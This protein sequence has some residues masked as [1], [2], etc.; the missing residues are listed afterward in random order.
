MSDIVA[1]RAGLP[2][3]IIRFALGQG[4]A[5]A[6]LGVLAAGLL[7]FALL[8]DLLED[9]SHGFDQAILLALRQPGAPDQPIGPAW[10]TLSIREV[11]ALGSIPVLFLL[12]LLALGYL[13]LDRRWRAAALLLVSLP[14]GLLVNTLLKDAFGRPRPDLVARLAEVQTASFPSGH[15]MLSAIGFLTLGALLAAGARRRRHRAY[16]L[17]MAALLTLL[18]GAS[19]VW[20][21]VH[22]PTDVLAGWCLGAAWAMACWLALRK[23]RGAA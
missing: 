3:R 17:T 5:L 11:T 20:L 14:G 4:A 2:Q 18:V 9:E 12:T 6:A 7:G 1:P 8:V 10:L 21:G 23:W 13:V 22:W 16:I 19:R 15:A